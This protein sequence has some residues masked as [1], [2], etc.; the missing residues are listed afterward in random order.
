MKVTFLYSVCV[1]VCVIGEEENRDI[2]T[3]SLKETRRRGRT[4]GLMKGR[5]RMISYVNLLICPIKLKLSKVK[6]S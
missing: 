5:A 1:C 6:F 2:G 4:V 3:A